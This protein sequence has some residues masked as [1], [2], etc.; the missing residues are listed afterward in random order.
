MQSLYKIGD[1]LLVSTP[2]EESYGIKATVQ[3]VYAATEIRILEY[4][5]CGTYVKVELAETL[6]AIWWRV[7]NFPPF[8]AQLAHD[9]PTDGRLSPLEEFLLS[10]RQLAFAEYCVAS[11][12]SQITA[13]AIVQMPIVPLKAS[14]LDIET[15]QVKVRNTSDLQTFLA[16]ESF[17]RGLQD[18]KVLGVYPDI[19]SP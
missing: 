13:M 17:N 8:L 16:S 3:D 11:N 2:A 12:D 15:G 10:R 14:D 5:L 9:D 18:V 19:S 1:R 7:E 6:Q 4:S